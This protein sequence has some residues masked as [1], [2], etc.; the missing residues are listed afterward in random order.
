MSEG[1]L[2]VSEMVLHMSEVVLFVSEIV[3]H[4]SEIVVHVSEIVLLVSEMVALVRPDVTRIV[5]AFLSIA[6]EPRNDL[7]DSGGFTKREFTRDFHNLTLLSVCLSVS[8]C[9]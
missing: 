5:D 1:V 3:L 4:V 6:D 9:Y 2:H 7:L 8:A